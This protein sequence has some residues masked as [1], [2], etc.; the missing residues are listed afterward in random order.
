MRV[1]AA[2]AAALTADLALAKLDVPIIALL[3]I[4]GAFCSIPW[5]S[6]RPRREYAIEQ[7][8]PCGCSVF[9]QYDEPVIT[10]TDW[11]VE[12]KALC[13]RGR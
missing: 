10:E 8:C 3:L 2:C 6:E 11:D 7:H 9:D 4:F 5:W 1:L 12:Y 13:E